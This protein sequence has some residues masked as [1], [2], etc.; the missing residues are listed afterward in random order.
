M[1]ASGTINIIAQLL[2]LGK[3]VDFIDRFTLTN[4]PAFTTGNMYRTQAVADTE[5]ALDLGGVSTVDLIVIKAVTNDLLIDTSYAA[6]TFSEEINVPEGEI[7]VFKPGATVYVMNE[8]AAEQVTYE[9]IVIG[10]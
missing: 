4:T 8:D 7:A 10:R 6:A 1:A 3:E 9:Y 2:G 5:E